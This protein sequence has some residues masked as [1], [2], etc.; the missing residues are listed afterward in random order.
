MDQFKIYQV[1]YF[2]IHYSGAGSAPPDHL[3][4]IHLTLKTLRVLITLML[5]D[6]HQYSI[7]CNR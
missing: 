2:S 3:A 4:H 5:W 1:T 6:G 7:F